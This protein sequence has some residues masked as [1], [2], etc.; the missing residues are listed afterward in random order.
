MD[1]FLN[2]KSNSPLTTTV[3]NTCVA[4]NSEVGFNLASDMNSTT[5]LS[6][7]TDGCAVSMKLASCYGVSFVSYSFEKHTKCGVHI[8]SPD[9]YAT[10]VSLSPRGLGD[11]KATN[12]KIERVGGVT[13]TDMY[14]SKAVIP[15][16]GYAIDVMRKSAPKFFLN[17]CVIKGKT[18]NLGE[19]T[20]V[21]SN[22]QKF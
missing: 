21:G 15:E 5:L 20:F 4:Y 17:N 7:C 12:I 22:Q 6:C 18:D 9:C 11:P 8:D 13:F 16:N 2:G 14:I 1:F 10:F 19:C 3:F